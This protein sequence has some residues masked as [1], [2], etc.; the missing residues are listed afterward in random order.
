[1]QERSWFF[2]QNVQNRSDCYSA[3]TYAMRY[4]RR[5]GMV[6]AVISV[7]FFFSRY[8]IT[9]Q[10]IFYHLRIS[11]Y[12]LS[13]LILVKYTKNAE[14]GSVHFQNV[15]HVLFITVV[16]KKKQKT[17]GGSRSQLFYFGSEFCIFFLMKALFCTIPKNM[18][19]Q[20]N[21]E[22]FFL[23][24]KFENPK[25]KKVKYTTTWRYIS[26]FRRRYYHSDIENIAN[27][28]P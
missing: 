19:S 10:G 12:H 1:M 25:S 14:F 27:V 13:V 28:F 8:K 24:H 5:S 9:T 3:P 21:A 26:H 23:K 2:L 17:V 6:Q 18:F 4:R 16:R 15:T 22:L 20:K 7:F 11:I